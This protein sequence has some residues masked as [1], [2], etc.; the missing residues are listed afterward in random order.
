[1]LRHRN[2]NE[3]E[4]KTDSENYRREGEV[5]L[6]AMCIII[7]KLK[8]VFGLAY[9]SIAF[10]RN[11]VYL[12]VHL[13]HTRRCYRCTILSGFCTTIS[14]Y[15]LCFCGSVRAWIPR[16][17]SL[18]RIE[19]NEVGSKGCFIYIC[20]KKNAII[21]LPKAFTWNSFF[22]LLFFVSRSRWQSFWHESFEN[23]INASTKT[24]STKLKSSEHSR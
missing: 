22:S 23:R 12:F 7:C 15:F 24:M 2:D 3:M 19:L 8:S 6:R 11:F 1:M 16:C 20:H 9:R 4:L 13:F 18:F 5:S 17:F 21:L 10:C 14:G